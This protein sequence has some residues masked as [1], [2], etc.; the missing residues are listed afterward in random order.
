MAIYLIPNRCT[1]GFTAVVPRVRTVYIYRERDRVTAIACTH[2]VLM[3]VFPVS[4]FLS[5]FKENKTE[6]GLQC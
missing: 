4:T 6:I 2:C 5:P 1:S 3:N